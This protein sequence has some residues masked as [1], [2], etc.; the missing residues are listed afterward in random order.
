VD[1]D[2]KQYFDTIN[3]DKLMYLLEK[4]ISDRRVL[5]LIRKYLKSG[6][7]SGGIFWKTEEGSPQGG[8][9]SPLISNIYLNEFD[10]LLESRGICFVRYADDCNIYVKSKRA[11]NRVMENCIKYLEGELKLTVNHEKSAVGSPLKRKFLGFCI[12][13]MKSGVKIRPHQKAKERVKEKLKK[14][15]KRNRGCSLEVIF[16]KIRQLMVGW[17]NYYGISEMKSFIHELNGW[18]KRRIRQIYWKQW[19]LPKA[20]KRELMAMGID[21]RK[22]KEWSNTRKGYWRISR[23]FITHRTLTDKELEK[24]GLINLTSLYTRVHLSY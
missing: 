15:T 10:C 7:L 2:M 23:S 9:I 11:G 17:V 13:P 3:H 24:R 19:K 8:P 1:I 12:N 4:K 18:L 16:E 14:L 21:E 5:N 22:A 20:R 6:I